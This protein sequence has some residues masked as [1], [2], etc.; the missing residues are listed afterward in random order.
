MKEV[1]EQYNKP[2]EIK[3]TQSLSV[4]GKIGVSWGRSG[5]EAGGI[6]RDTYLAADGIENVLRVLE[7][8]E[9]EKLQ[10][11]DFIELNACSGG[12][13]GGVL[14]VENPY[15][16]KVKLNVLR[17]YLP[18]SGA[19]LN[20]E[21]PELAYSKEKIEYLPIFNLS[22]NIEESLELLNRIEQLVQVLPGLDCGC[23][24]APTCRA[25]A[26]D[27]VRGEGSEKDCI[28]ILK[29]YI[30]EFSDEINKIR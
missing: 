10:N 24:G 12:C 3:S 30:H 19:H 20:N 8:L 14:A 22:G 11:L 1:Y 27:I 9:D 15:L 7:D 23:C 21:I 28:F 26:E 29:R 16:A 5:G 2:G 6:L 25:L 13:V 18:V 4:A 17:K